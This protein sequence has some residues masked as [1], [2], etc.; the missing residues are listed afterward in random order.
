MRIV[1]P[2][3][4]HVKVSYLPL[5]KDPNT[6]SP[7]PATS[8]DPKI[9]MPRLSDPVPDDWETIDDHFYLVYALNLSWLD[10][11]T[12]LAPRVE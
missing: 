11:L 1:F 2:K 5:K 9:D 3:A 6:G 12:L 8:G 7:I 4:Y 10:P